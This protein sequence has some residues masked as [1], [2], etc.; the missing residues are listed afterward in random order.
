MLKSSFKWRINPAEV[1][2]KLS[3][4]PQPASRGWHVTSDNPH[5]GVLVRPIQDAD[6]GLS[7]D[8]YV[9]LQLSL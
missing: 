4:G 2:V 6:T 1:Y 8:T 7:S 3:W 9:H 5:T